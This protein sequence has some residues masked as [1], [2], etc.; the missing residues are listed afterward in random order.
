[1]ETLADLASMQHHQQPRQNSLSSL[2][3][4]ETYDKG[5]TSSVYCQSLECSPTLRPQTFWGFRSRN[6]GRPGSDSPPRVFRATSLSEADLQ[7]ITQLTGALAENSYAY[8]THV[9]LINL[10]HQGLISH[11]YP[12]D[13]TSSAPQNPRDYSLLS[14]L[15]QARDAM[16]SRFAVGEDLWKDWLQDESL[17]ATTSEER[18]HVTELCQ[19][20]VTE[21]PASVDIWL[22]YAEWMWSTYAAANG[23][24]DAD[25][26]RWTEDDRMI[27]REVFTR[28]EVDRVWSQ[29]VEATKWRIDESHR[30]WDR[31]LELIMQDFPDKPTPSQ[32]E[33][34]QQVFFNRLEIP[35]ATSAETSQ[36]FWPIISRYNG[37]SWEEIMAATNEMAAPAKQQY[38]L[39][40]E[41]ELNVKR[42]V[43]ADDKVTLYTVLSDYLKWEKRHR[44]RSP[45]DAEL[46]ATLYER[47]L[48]KFPATVDLWLD[49][50]DFLLGANKSSLPILPVLER[51][52]R[53]CP[54]SGELW[55]RR[56]LRAEVQN[57]SYDEIDNIKHRATNSGLLNIGGMEEMIKV[58]TAW[59]S[60]LRRRA[61]QPD[62]TDDEI[63]MADMGILGTIEDVQVAGRKIYGQSFQGDPLYRIEQIYV[64]F[65]TEARRMEDAR[66]I[67]RRLAETTGAKSADFWIGYYR[68]ENLL[69]GFERL[70]DAVRVETPTNGPHRSTAVLREAIKHKDLDWPEKLLEVFAYHFQTHESAEECERGMTE[71]R[72]ATTSVQQRRT[73]EAAD[74]AAAAPAQQQYGHQYVAVEDPSS[75]G[76]RKRE[77]ETLQNGEAVLKRSRTEELD[78]DAT[79]PPYNEASSSASAQ[80]KRD[81]E[82]NTIT[83][84]NLPS[85]IAE[86]RLRHFFKDCGNIMG[87]GVV[88]DSDAMTSTATIEFESTEDVLA[89]KTRDGKEI[90]GNA[91]KIQSGTLSTLYV[92]NYPPD[93]DE[94]KIRELFQDYGTVVS[95]RFPSL[96]YNQRRRFCYIQFLT[97]NEARAA[98]VMND[99]AIDGQHKLVALISDPEA[100]KSRQGATAEGR[101]LYV[102]NV[103]FK[104]T[105]DEIRQFFA[106]HGTVE[107]IKLVRGTNDRAT[108]VI[109]H[110]TSGSPGPESTIEKDAM[111]ISGSTQ[112]DGSGR[113]GS[114][115]S[116]A[117]RDAPVA[118][119]AET[120]RS[121]RERT[122]AL[123][124]IPDTVNDARIQSFMETYGPLRKITVRRD[125][126][127]ALIEFVNL[128]DAGKVGMGIDASALGPDVRV[129]DAEEVMSKKSG[130][131]AGNG[132]GGAMPMRPTQAGVSRPQQ[133]GGRRG[134]LGFKRGGL[135]GGTGGG[136]TGNGASVKSNA[137]FR[138]MF[139]KSGSKDGEKDTGD[140]VAE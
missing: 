11:M 31:W 9:Q 84:K 97:A 5:R 127:T 34:V 58:Y 110:A 3:S 86:A 45:F 115:A 114:V 93:F 8:D 135:G 46:Q 82:H 35:H 28:E 121:K 116:Y 96:K 107:S 2:K 44:R 76:K 101:E 19:K 131:G 112:Q 22:I 136:D 42:A 126:G 78:A 71:Y 79:K 137:D 139:V 77:D 66:N 55:S 69:W 26:D 106:Q 128:A 27:C 72:A 100:K 109:Q 36:K 87:I 132:V 38:G 130:A 21:E 122:I 30:I 29:A 102:G 98:T 89:A 134:G 133:R 1:M 37:N 54:W 129:G 83:V 33:K 24:V 70:S 13:A 65:L 99:K 7:S 90:D 61:F 47:S 39:R 73:K 16:D 75:V 119:A 49:Y 51:A 88:T 10:L 113:C 18:T 85:A 48:L 52:T 120:A 74:A 81:R 138:A 91:I 117:E 23:F 64:K 14:E 60:Y 4:A 57:E 123:L 118:S 67:Y 53:H 32:L 94:I 62:N 80:I 104:A 25:P 105:E 12:P 40:E 108:K 50:V 41:Y 17:I 6:G 63:D 95:V 124:N 56:L 68:F 125:K 59:C 111:D 103:D 140:G 15:R 92:T 20:A 43:E